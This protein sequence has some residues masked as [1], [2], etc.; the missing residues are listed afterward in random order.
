MISW[1]INLIHHEFPET[2]SDDDYYYLFLIHC[3]FLHRLYK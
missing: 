1:H 3:D 2:L